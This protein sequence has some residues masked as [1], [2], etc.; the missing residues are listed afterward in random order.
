MQD[1][2]EEEV[3]QQLRNTGKWS[4]EQ[5]RAGV[6]AE[7]KC[8]YCGL[9]LLASVENYKLWQLDHIVPKKLIEEI[10]GNPENIENLAIA[11]KACNYDFKWRFDPRQTAELNPDRKALIEA[12][13]EHIGERKAACAEDLARVRKIVG[14]PPLVS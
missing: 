1:V 10:H 9:D 5:A 2:T 6:R 8:E 13:I 7:F 4:P 3:V 12:A 11:C 14:R